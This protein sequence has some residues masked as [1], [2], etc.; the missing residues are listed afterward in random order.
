MSYSVL[1]SSSARYEEKSNWAMFVVQLERQLEMHPQLES[2]HFSAWCV[3]FQQSARAL[4]EN[5][6]DEM[7]LESVQVSLRRRKDRI[8]MAARNH[9][10]AQNPR[11]PTNLDNV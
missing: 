8:M 11:R 5:L 7:K 1:A 6:K 2:G 4:T 10:Q 9:L 3:H